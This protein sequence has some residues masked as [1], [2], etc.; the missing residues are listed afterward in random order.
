VLVD[1][2]EELV[3]RVDRVHPLSPVRAILLPTK[4]KAARRWWLR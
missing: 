1:Q 4:R 3:A 2:V